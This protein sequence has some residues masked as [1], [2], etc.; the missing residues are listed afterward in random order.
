M[1][2]LLHQ[3]AGFFSQVFF[4]MNRYIYCKK[5]HKDFTLDTENWIFLHEKGWTDY[6]E[7]IDLQLENSNNDNYRSRYGHGYVIKDV[8]LWVLATNSDAKD[9]LAFEIRK[10]E[11]I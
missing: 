2:S 5:H 1:I 7:P 4:T 3:S 10:Y 9:K 8:S 6:F 11:N